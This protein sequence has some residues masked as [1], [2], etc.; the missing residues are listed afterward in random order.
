[1]NVA[2][3]PLRMTR[4]QFFA[5]AEA[6]EARHEFDGSRPVAM[7]RRYRQ[8][9]P[10]HPERAAGAAPA[11]ARHAMPRARPGCRHRHRRRSRPPPR[12]AGHLLPGARQRPSGTQP[13]RGV[14]G[15]QP[16]FRPHRPHRQV[17][18]I[19]RGALDPSLRAAGMVGRRAHCAGTRA[20]RRA[21]DRDRP[22]RDR[23][24]A[25]SRDRRRNSGPGV[26]PGRRSADRQRNVF[27]LP[28]A[29]R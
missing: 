3:P 26:L 20:R 22:G 16:R 6:Q 15:A 25:S 21:M 8:P 14:R 19:P 27:D 29:N 12:R 9:Q 13:S 28:R 24:A 18:R 2:L 17:A 5:W 1:M 11:A 7:T 23:H 10:D 4:A